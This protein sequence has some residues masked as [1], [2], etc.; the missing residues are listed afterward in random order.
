MVSDRRIGF[1]IVLGACGRCRWPAPAPARTFRYSS[2]RSTAQQPLLDRRG[3]SDGSRTRRWRPLVLD[4]GRATPTWAL[5]V[6]PIL[7]TVKESKLAGFDGGTVRRS[8]TRHGTERAVQRCGERRIQTDAT[9]GA[10]AVAT[11]PVAFD[12]RRASA[13]PRGFRARDLARRSARD[14]SATA[15]RAPHHGSTELTDP[16][17]RPRGEPSTTATPRAEHLKPTRQGGRSGGSR[18]R[19]SRRARS[20]GTAVLVQAQIGELA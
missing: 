4:M 7:P 9:P 3:A 16:V 14:F 2:T 20:S 5:P 1:G 18:A 6:P 19:R 8:S 13:R 11:S 10:V 17:R 15:A 12:R